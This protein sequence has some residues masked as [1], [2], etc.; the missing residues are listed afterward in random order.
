LAL[1]A[2]ARWSPDSGERRLAHTDNFR[3]LKGISESELDKQLVLAQQDHAPRRRNGP[4]AAAA[5]VAN[6]RI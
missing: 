3:A 4:R 1:E 6:R 5:R 2:T